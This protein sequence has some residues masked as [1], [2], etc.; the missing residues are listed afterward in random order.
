M[1][2]GETGHKMRWRA[3]GDEGLVCLYEITKRHGE[4]ARGVSGM[5]GGR[6]VH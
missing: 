3:G 1:A 6:G 4:D 2:G 5:I